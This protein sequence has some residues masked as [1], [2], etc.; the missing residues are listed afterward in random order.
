MVSILDLNIWNYNEPWT[1]RREGIAR[2]IREAS[3]DLVAL[4]EVRYSSRYPESPHHQ[5]DQ[6][7]AHLEGYQMVWQPAMYYTSE[8]PQVTH[9]EGLAILSRLP[10]VDRRMVWLAR[11]R[12]D[13]RDEHQ[14]IVLGARVLDAEGP[15]W[16]FTTHLSLSAKAR[17][18]TV[19]EVLRFARDTA[20]GEPFALTG[21]LNAEP[22]ELPIRFLRGEERMERRT[23][24]LF[25][26]WTVA[27]GD[28]PGYTYS[29]WEP[30]KRID[31]MFVPE[32]SMVR[33]IA[34]AADKPDAE[35]VYP[36]DHLGLYAE[37]TW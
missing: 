37:L 4:Q 32:A 5:A 25:D 9:W 35:G 6:I 10:V 3:P 24:N 17:E 7:A 28:E 1:K 34:I 19:V 31:Y 2:T 11:D 12:E 13:A 36:S 16:L 21:D 15:F 18:R 33:H 30:V 14:R 22:H 29:A 8:S 20:A 23:S 27:H 26:A